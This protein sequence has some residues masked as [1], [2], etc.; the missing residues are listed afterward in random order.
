M[1]GA[2]GSPARASALL[3][4][5]LAQRLLENLDRMSAM[6]EMAVIDDDRRDGLDALTMIELLLLPH[7][8]CVGVR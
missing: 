8:F 4:G 5:N 7:L 1:Q 3:G 6:D 2:L